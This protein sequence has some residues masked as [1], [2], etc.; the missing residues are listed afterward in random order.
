MKNKLSF[1]IIFTA[2]FSCNQGEKNKTIDDYLPPI[3]NDSARNL[4]KPNTDF[5]KKSLS[6]GKDTLVFNLEMNNA[7]H[8]VTV[9]INISACDTLLA[10]LSSN[11]K[12]ANIRISQ[13]GFP[14]S[15]FDGPFGR[16]LD[17]KIKASGNY[18]IIIGEDMMAGNRWNGDF[19]LKVWVK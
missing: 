2:L 5:I 12:K 4:S 9:P 19:S 7:N 15:T 13:I 11:D 1:L 6:P 8:H 18:K 14:D 16:N 17:Y 3:T 10:S